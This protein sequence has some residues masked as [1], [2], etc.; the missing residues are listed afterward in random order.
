[1][2]V[3]RF[4]DMI[5]RQLY[6]CSFEEWSSDDDEAEWEWVWDEEE[7]DQELDHQ[8]NQEDKEVLCDI[9]LKLI[10]GYIEDSGKGLILSQRI[11]SFFAQHHLAFSL[12]LCCLGPANTKPNGRSK[13]LVGGCVCKISNGNVFPADFNRT[14]VDKLPDE[15]INTLMLGPSLIK[16]PNK[17]KQMILAQEDKGFSTSNKNGGPIGDI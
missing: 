2:F 8:C 17:L 4:Q 6:E 12:K 9:Q 15:A 3:K 14:F 1:M 11:L 7:D 13:P 10:G 5:F 16:K